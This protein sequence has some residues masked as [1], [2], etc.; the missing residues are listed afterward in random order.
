MS[1]SS[2]FYLFL[3]IHLMHWSEW[4]FSTMH[5][6]PTITILYLFYCHRQKVIQW[7]VLHCA[8]SWILNG[9]M[10]QERLLAAR[11]GWDKTSPS[12]VAQSCK[13]VSLHSIVSFN[14][15]SSQ[16]TAQLLPDLRRDGKKQLTKLGITLFLLGTTA[17]LWK[18]YSDV[19][20]FETRTNFVH[21]VCTSFLT[22]SCSS[23][24]G[25]STNDASI[26]PVQIY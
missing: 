13:S 16:M 22:L 20:T 7:R 6:S 19:W 8:C 14:L 5:A 18:S 3:W 2:A 26:V 4:R 12:K 9:T 15:G 10:N 23:N 25:L 21:Q 24:Y 17:L 11:I 1:I